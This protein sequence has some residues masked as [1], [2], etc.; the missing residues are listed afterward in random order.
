MELQRLHETL[1]AEVRGVDL[2]GEVSPAEIEALRAALA[3]HQLLLFRLDRPMA[4]ERQ[5][6][7]AGS[8]G[9]V[10]RGD[11]DRN[12]SVLRN[13]SAAGRVELKFHSDFTYTDDPIQRICLHAIELPPGGTATAF[14]SGV[15]AWGTLPA[16][17]QD[18]LAP[19]TLRHVQDGSITA[20]DLPVFVADHPVRFDHPQVG[21]PVLLVT[22]YHARRIHEL[23]EAR[24]REVLD[25]LFAH[26][27]RPQSIYVHHWRLH[28][29]IIWDNLAIQ[30]ARPAS[31]EPQD[32]PRALQ[33]V[34]LGQ[35]DY[36]ELVA[37]ARRRE[38]A[39]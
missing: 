8:F 16:D 23:P 1:G 35:A 25:R 24:S 5:V 39:A 11:G 7:F 4:P 2:L 28:D 15:H 19:M 13:D 26:L 6:D 17:L 9:P 18:L 14:V 33:R 3:E 12:W 22:E 29:L 38:A 30:H 34:A 31:A 10:L 20:A 37:R 32:G 36:E 27:Y 21:R